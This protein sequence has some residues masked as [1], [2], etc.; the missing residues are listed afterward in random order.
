MPHVFDFEQ[1]ERD[2]QRAC[3]LGVRY[4]ADHYNSDPFYAVS[5]YCDGFDGCFGLYANTE[6]DFQK[7]LAVYK[8][9]YP[10][11]Y[12]TSLDIKDLKYNC[13]D[14]EYQSAGAP[15]EDF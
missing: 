9:T 13:G 2:F 12:K 11:S 3:V 4:L 14:W 6:V 8:N 1:F 15:P 7:T 5:L 10:D